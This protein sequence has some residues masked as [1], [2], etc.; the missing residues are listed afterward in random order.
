MNVRGWLGPEGAARGPAVPVVGMGDISPE[1]LGDISGIRKK[2][3][4][5]QSLV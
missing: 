3:A 5:S 1:C 2:A 4:A